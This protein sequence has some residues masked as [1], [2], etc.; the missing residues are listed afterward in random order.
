MPGE[1]REELAMAR[2]HATAEV[3]HVRLYRW[4]L[5][6]AAW[7]S[8]SIVARALYVELANRYFGNNNGQIAYSVRQAAEEFKI[9][10]DTAS[11][12][13]DQLQA[14]GFITVGR[15][16]GFNLKEHKGQATEW[17]LTEHPCGEQTFATKE[18]TRWTE[19]NDFPVAKGPKPTRRR[20]DQRPEQPAHQSP[21]PMANY[22]RP[23]RGTSAIQDSG[24][25]SHD[26]D[27]NVTSAQHQSRY[28]DELVAT[29]GPEV[30]PE[31]PCS[32][33]KNL[34]STSRTDRASAARH[35]T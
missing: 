35:E 6:S 31:G 12:A 22:K 4:M 34:A 15:K 9:S 2:R 28:R 18:F 19:G 14:R 26:K 7:K 17:R 11:R 33:A 16:G 30:A 5:K 20:G 27:Q 3:S 23:V 24:F 25:E 13:F 29:E 8:L 1:D 10:K 32:E 21:H